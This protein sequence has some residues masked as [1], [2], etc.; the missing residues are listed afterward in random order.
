MIDTKSMY[1]KSLNLQEQDES[2]DIE[3]QPPFS[4]GK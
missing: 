2:S 1:K 3:E 4:D